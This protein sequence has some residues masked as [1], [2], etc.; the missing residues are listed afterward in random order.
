MVGFSYKNCRISSKVKKKQTKYM[1]VQKGDERSKHLVKVYVFSFYLAVLFL[2]SVI[3][4]FF[5]I[6]DLITKRPR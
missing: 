5:V 2:F 6:L 1:L 3:G 4:F